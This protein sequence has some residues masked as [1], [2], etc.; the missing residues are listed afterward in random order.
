MLRTIRSPLIRRMSR[1]LGAA[2]AAALLTA[3]S[4]PGMFA[5]GLGVASAAEPLTMEARV[6]LQG[7][8]RASAWVGVEIHVENDGPAVVGELR[9]LGGGSAGLTRIARAVE[10]PTQSAQTFLLFAQPQQFGRSFTVE[11]VANG[12]RI[13]SRDVAYQLHDA[14][15]MTVGIVAERP[16]Q[17]A[18]ALQL[19]VAGIEPGGPGGGKFGAGQT[20]VIG[21]ALADLP[22]RV[23]GWSALD[24]LIWQD[25][26]TSGLNANQVAALKTWLA[27][28]GRLIVVGGAS[29]AHALNGFPDDI[30]PYRPVATVDA[31]PATLAGLLREIPDDAIDVPALAGELVRG[32]ALAEVG[33]RTIAA[34]TTYGSGSVTLI[35]VDPTAS[36]I[37]ESRST[38][39]LWV[40]LLPPRTS[41]S[42]TLG[43]DSQ[44]VSAVSQ[45][46]SLALPPIGGMLLL[47]GA[48]ILLIG[49]INYLVLKRLDRREWAWLTMPALIALFAVGA[50]GVGALLRG[51]DVLLNQ[52]AIVRGAPGTTEGEA[53]VYVGVFS[54]SR[55]TYDVEV[56]GGALL[57]SPIVGDFSGDGSPLDVLQGEPSR[58]RNLTVGF[59]S[60]RTIRALTAT[61]VPLVDVDIALVDGSLTGTITNR[62]DVRLERPAIVLGGGVAVLSDLAP[63]ETAQVRISSLDQQPGFSLSD[64]IFGQS[65][66]GGG[67]IDDA[68]RTMLVRRSI[69]DQ[70]TYDPQFGY[71]GTLNA[72]TAVLLTWADGGLLDVR[73][74]GQSPRTTGTTLY[75]LPIRME[76]SGKTTFAGGLV[77]GTVESVDA[78]DFYRD[79]YTISLG[80][81]SVTMAYQPLAIGGT[82]TP[83]RVDLAMTFGGDQFEGSDGGPI[84]PLAEI[85]IPCPEPPAEQPPDCA[86][87]AFDGA[88]EVEVFDRVAGEWRRLP[89]M[90][91]G[92]RRSLVDPERYVDPATGVIRVRFVAEG[93]QHFGFGFQ[94]RLVGDVS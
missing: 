11:L 13:A 48:Y 87:P 1:L 86:R 22:E 36:W 82:F 25:V 15:Q 66:F 38:R 58:V 91:M 45:L 2:F 18:G 69:I 68:T 70:L 32:T 65:F 33:D 59:G 57:G 90:A 20:V 94:V 63:G 71:S 19:G 44:L 49:P 28:G 43:D 56:P 55:A 74:A 40:R 50:F 67:T 72:D 21:L 34:E 16:Q 46:P 39:D 61:S 12:E 88:P 9:I 75:Y 29:G 60:L 30:L 41:S 80:P 42:V 24:R 8:A 54:P 79:P 27:G 93:Q 5:P 83:T 76:I 81:G 10:I 64:R 6:L 26:D 73:I 77:R 92:Q 35:G 17:I 53:Q 89:H 4:L 47:L 23:E 85:P 37:G 3:S 62:S 84:A 7:H 78:L 14:N 31:P 51:T 52:I